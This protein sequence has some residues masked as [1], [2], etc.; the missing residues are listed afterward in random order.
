MAQK[1][2][3]RFLA[4]AGYETMNCMRL[5]D[6]DSAALGSSR[7]LRVAALANAEGHALERLG[8]LISLRHGTLLRARV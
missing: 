1:K 7:G 2:P 8:V 6:V 4:Q 3:K 5:V